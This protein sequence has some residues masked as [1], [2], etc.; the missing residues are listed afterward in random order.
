MG[1]RT[2]H[3]LADR[4]PTTQPPLR[5]PPPQLPCLPRTRRSHL[6][7]QATSPPHHIGHG[8]RGPV[9]AVLAV[10]LF[11]VPFAWVTVARRAWYRTRLEA[12]TPAPQGSP[13]IARENTF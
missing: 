11:G 1:H 8:L 5:A 10:L 3:L 13:V 9:L 12:A 2:H 7:L 6:L 4:L